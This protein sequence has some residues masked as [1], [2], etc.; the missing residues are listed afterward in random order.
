MRLPDLV[1]YQAA[2]QHPGTAF[3]DADLRAAT[4]TTTRLGL[5]RV[6]AGNFALTYQ[7]SQAGRR[8]A[9]RCFHRDAM[10]RAKRYAA[11]SQ[12][13]ATIRAGPLVTIAYLPAGVRVDQNWFPITKMPWLDGRPFNRAV[14]ASLGSP[15]ALADLEQRFIALLGD[16]RKFGLAHGDLQHGN[17]LVDPSGALKLVDYDGMFVPDLRAMRASES[18]D[19]NYQHPGRT[20]QFDAELD[21]FAALVIV[22]ALRVLAQ[23][24][25][26]WRTYNTDDNLL[27]RRTDFVSPDASALFRDL[28]AQPATRDLAER[29]ARVCQSDYALVPTV[30]DFLQV[31]VQPR[32]VGTSRVSEIASHSNHTPPSRS[33][34]R[35]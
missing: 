34:N 33:S 29:F 8:W 25:N 2:V 15:S 1:A 13:L 4:V 32:P 18:G 28:R 11:I 17:I 16:L 3:G 5:P 31:K 22:V 24:P 21:R 9:V 26:L 6:A 23:A 20:L 30:A 35:Q 19:P 7:L 14:E 27:F 10:D 12:T